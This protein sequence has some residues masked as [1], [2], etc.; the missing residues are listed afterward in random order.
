MMNFPV[1]HVTT[2]FLARNCPT[3]PR[4]SLAAIARQRRLVS[5]E[6]LMVYYEYKASNSECMINVCN[7][8]FWQFMGWLKHWVYHIKRVGNHT[9]FSRRWKMRRV[10]EWFKVGI[11]QW[12]LVAE[13]HSSVSP[14]PRIP[15]VG[16]TH[17][18]C[19]DFLF[20][21]PAVCPL[22]KGGRCVI[23]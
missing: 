16:S 3:Y 7:T 17:W 22:Q 5:G 14:R 11:S 13:A 8:H 15:H 12:V 9:G 2:G 19:I 23:I 6:L 1:N 21:K 18:M 20:S 10:L 4:S